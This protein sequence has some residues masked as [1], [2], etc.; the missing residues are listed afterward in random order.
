MLCPNRLQLDWLLPNCLSP[1]MVSIIYYTAPGSRHLAVGLGPLP[2]KVM[3]VSARA[4][5]F[6]PGPALAL[7][8]G[9]WLTTTWCEM[10]VQLLA[11]TDTG[12][13]LLHSKTRWLPL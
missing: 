4:V 11:L 1:Q 7:G 5:K 12:P 13:P 8:E 10:P 9:F 6:C 3:V 2:P